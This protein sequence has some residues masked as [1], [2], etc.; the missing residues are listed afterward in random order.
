MTARRPVLSSRDVE[1]RHTSGD[2]AYRR[3]S[4]IFVLG[5]RAP[6]AEWLCDLACRNPGG[7]WA[8]D[9][10]VRS[11]RAAE[12]V[13]LAIIGDRDSAAA[14]DWNWA[15]SRGAREKLYQKDKDET[16]FQLAISSF[17]RDARKKVLIASGCFGG[18]MDHLMSNF[19]TL[20]SS[21][22]DFSRCMA[23][24]SEGAFFLFSGEEARLDFSRTPEAVSLIPATDVC[25]GVDISGV[26]WPLE[27]ETLEM[28]RLWAISNETIPGA[29]A[30]QPVKARCGEGILAVYWRFGRADSR[31]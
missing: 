27:D 13:P 30:P 18:A 14:D 16:D 12:L 25:S 19:H 5:G 15:V 4:V 8:V 29:N 1:I 31:G 9:S 24:E 6:D 11:C 23:D 17:V 7:V 3:E 26:K 22:G 21:R 20:A 28:S 2:D 10:G